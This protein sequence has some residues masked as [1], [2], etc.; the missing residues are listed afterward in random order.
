VNFHYGAHSRHRIAALPRLAPFTQN[1]LLVFFSAMTARA[2]IVT[3]WENLEL[4][5]NK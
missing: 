1:D 3:P 2:A 4:V 5:T